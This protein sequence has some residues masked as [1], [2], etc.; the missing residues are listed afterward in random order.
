[1][2]NVFATTSKI[3][4]WFKHIPEN[5]TALTTGIT[6]DI[7]SLISSLILKTPLW[8]FDNEWFG[9]TTYLFSIVAVGIVSTLTIIEGMKRKFNKKDGRT[10]NRS[11]N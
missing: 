11:N 6:S 3:I 10:N 5:V 7:Y 9:N 1:M 4:E 8:L 2:Q